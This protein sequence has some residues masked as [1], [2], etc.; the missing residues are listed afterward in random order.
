M[1]IDSEAS[2]D[3]IVRYFCMHQGDTISALEA[4]SGSILALRPIL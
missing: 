3:I 1:F 4:T 2:F